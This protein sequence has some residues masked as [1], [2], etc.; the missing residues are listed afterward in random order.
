[1][2]KSIFPDPENSELSY[3]R[4]MASLLELLFI[5]IINVKL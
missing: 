5:K 4:I 3:V 1:M 2:G